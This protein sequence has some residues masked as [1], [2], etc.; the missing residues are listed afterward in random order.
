[1]YAIENRG[2][3]LGDRAGI[4][5]RNLLMGLIFRKSLLLPQYALIRDSLST[6]QIVNVMEDA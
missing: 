5:T 4:S 3:I 2:W 1:M 6:G